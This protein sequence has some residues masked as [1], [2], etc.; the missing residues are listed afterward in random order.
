MTPAQQ[1]WRLP[2]TADHASCRMARPQH[3]QSLTPPS[4]GGCTCDRTA[5]LCQVCCIRLHPRAFLQQQGR[6]GRAFVCRAWCICGCSTAISYMWSVRAAS[7]AAFQGLRGPVGG[8]GRLQ[9][10][11][12][13]KQALAVGNLGVGEE[14]RGSGGRLEG[15]Q[16]ER[17]PS[18]ACGFWLKYLERGVHLGAARCQQGSPCLSCPGLRSR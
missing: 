13:D 11:D 1:S 3:V 15:W 12:S 17:G 18:C 8:C 10:V 5:G 4:R 2:S 7:T 14:W 6:Q 9:R 16:L